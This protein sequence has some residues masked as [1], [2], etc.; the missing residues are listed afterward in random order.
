MKPGEAGITAARDGRIAILS[1]R[2]G[3]EILTE[4]VAA[5]GG[6]PSQVKAA[7]LLSAIRSGDFGHWARS[8]SR[9]AGCPPISTVRQPGGSTGPPPCL[10]QVCASP[11]RATGCPM[12][13]DSPG[14]PRPVSS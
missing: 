10:G 3:D 2:G 8:P 7:E 5:S 4:L 12:G 9:A 1:F 11:A 13:V 6:E 14:I